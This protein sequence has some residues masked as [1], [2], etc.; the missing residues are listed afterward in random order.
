MNIPTRS[1]ITLQRHQGQDFLQW[2]NDAQVLR[3]GLKAVANALQELLKNRVQTREDARDLW[4]A[5]PAVMSHCNELDIYGMPGSAPA[6]AWLHFLE[7][8]VRTWLALQKLVKQNLLPM[9]KEGVRALDVG[10]GP[11]PSAF[12]T[13]D[14]YA[15]M[16][17]YAE[18]S[19]N[20]HW[21]QPAQ[22]T[23]VESA[24]KMNHYRH[25]LAEILFEQGAPE[26]ILAM[27]SNIPDF[28]S[29]H[30]RQE[31]KELYK[32][33]RNEYEN[34]DDESSN[35]WDS[36]PLYAPQEA[37]YI[38]NKHH[39]YRLFTFSNFLTTLTTIKCYRQNLTD[40]LTDAHPGSVLLVIGGDYPDVYDEVATL[41]EATGFS[42]NAEDL[43]VSISD[44]AMDD[45]IY[46]EGVHFYRRLKN[47]AQ[48]L[49]DK[50]IAQD[51]P[52]KDFAKLLKLAKKVAA[53]FEKGENHTAPSFSVIRA[54]R[55]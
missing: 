16:V 12:A 27:C 40:I 41:A 36:T 55:K 54:Y 28:K 18:V 37:N 10:T 4:A 34:Y 1:W 9:G 35:E 43:R 33:L 2:L 15:A 8:Y 44:T 49:P 30:P 14:F 7:R 11:G 17:K 51:L 48:D 19:K 23:C 31:R 25:H 39:R 22:L 42:R 5:V 45:I 3:T 50:S 26:G 24:A 6:Y 21:R 52:S 32:G 47:I 46:C 13:H 29:I 53:H 20:E 38:A